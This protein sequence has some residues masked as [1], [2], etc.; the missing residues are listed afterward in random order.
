MPIVGGPEDV[1]AARASRARRLTVLRVPLLG[2]ALGAF[3]GVLL[4]H[5][6]AS[7]APQFPRLRMMLVVACAS[8]SAWAL[9][10]LSRIQ[11]K[12]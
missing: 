8:L 5:L 10:R 9:W 7:V 2:A 3:V 6:N 1:F 11:R 12:R 4:V